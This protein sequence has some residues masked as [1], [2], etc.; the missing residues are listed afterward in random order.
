LKINLSI[1]ECMLMY[2][3]LYIIYSIHSNSN[4][5]KKQKNKNEIDLQYVDI[6]DIVKYLMDLN[7]FSA[8]LKV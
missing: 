5:K 1:I 4:E 2:L 6:P 3:Y 8:C 7:S